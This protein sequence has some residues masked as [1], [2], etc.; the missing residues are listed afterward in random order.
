VPRPPLLQKGGETSNTEIHPG[1]CI[2]ISLKKE[3]KL[4]ALKFFQG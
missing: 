4:P 1:I 2:K 3:G